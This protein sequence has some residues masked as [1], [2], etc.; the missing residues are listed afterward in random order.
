MDSITADQFWNHYYRDDFLAL[1]RSISGYS[2]TVPINPQA[3][4][5]PLALLKSYD[6][7]EVVIDLNELRRYRYDLDP[8]FFL[9]TRRPEQADTA[10]E[11]VVD[12]S[13]PYRDPAPFA[14][15]RMSE[16][17]TELREAVATGSD[18]AITTVWL[19]NVLDDLLETYTPDIAQTVAALTWFLGETRE[20]NVAPSLIRILER[21]DYTSVTV[22]LHFTIVDAAFA[23]L[24]KVNDKDSLPMII[25]VMRD[26]DATGRWKIAA[27]LSKLLSTDTML[28]AELLDDDY[29]D[30]EFWSGLHERLSHEW[31][32]RSI[33]FASKSLYW[34]V[35]YTAALRALPEDREALKI[36]A[37]DI[38]PF[39]AAKARQKQGR[40]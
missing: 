34:E 7:T 24:W 25:A 31:Q 39:I 22:P 33:A 27:L 4:A 21:S 29:P 1:E 37:D 9:I 14:P 15:G 38:V 10:F 40:P 12:S 23:A 5:G 3:A 35:R 28:S 8:R 2:G 6:T 20:R 18:A 36:L 19:Q 26:S 13:Y 32:E 11:A 30:P 16:I 17:F